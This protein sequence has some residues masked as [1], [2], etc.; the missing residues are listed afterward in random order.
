MFKKG[1]KIRR[2]GASKIDSTVP[3]ASIQEDMV[4]EILKGVPK[5]YQR[6]YELCLRGKK[7]LRNAI[8]MTCYECC[9]FEDAQNRVNECLSYRCPLWNY[10][11][12][13]RKNA[14]IEMP[15]V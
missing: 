7:A 3:K 6:R 8:N 9:C 4:Q 14:G 10:R 2:T 13:R 12:I 5:D 1:H 11:P 15:K